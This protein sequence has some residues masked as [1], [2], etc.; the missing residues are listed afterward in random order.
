MLI[1]L[2]MPIVLLFTLLAEPKVGKT[3]A[4]ML[5]EDSRNCRNCRHTYSFLADAKDIAAAIA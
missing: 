1:L 5:E 3:R 4:K 2:V